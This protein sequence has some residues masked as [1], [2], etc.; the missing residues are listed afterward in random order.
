MPDDVELNLIQ[1]P[2]RE[3]RYGEPMLTELKTV[4]FGIVH[5]MLNYIDTPYI[6]F[7]HS[8][9]VMV[10]SEVVQELQ[11]MH[12]PLPQHM[13]L[14]SLPN[15]YIDHTQHEY[16]LKIN[17]LDDKAFIQELIK[18]GVVSEQFINDK[19]TLNIFLPI[20]RADFALLGTTF[21]LNEIL[22]VP[23]TTIYCKDDKSVSESSLSL[24]QN[25]TRKNYQ[26]ITL[27]GGHLALMD[28][29]LPFIN[30]IKTIIK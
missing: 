21:I 27:L 15:H 29:P 10:A 4:A 7:A 22:D 16:F 8:M 2:G 12:L 19:E 24:W 6:I 1:L 30:V 17:N 26:N 5:A 13:I 14:S 11:K 20:L 23:I 18:T 25:V 28:D 3:Q 9:G